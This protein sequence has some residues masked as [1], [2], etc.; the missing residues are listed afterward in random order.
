MRDRTLKVHDGE[1][2]LF[3]DL[4]RIPKYLGIFAFLA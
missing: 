3:N 2:G 4:P 1:I